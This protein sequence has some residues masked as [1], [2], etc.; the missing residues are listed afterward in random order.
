MKNKRLFNSVALLITIISCTACRLRT[1]N[2]DSSQ[3]YKNADN[4]YM[5]Y[6]SLEEIRNQLQNNLL[7]NKTVGI[8]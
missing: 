7:N 3:T 5:Q 1:P 2:L 6:A 8:T 4:D